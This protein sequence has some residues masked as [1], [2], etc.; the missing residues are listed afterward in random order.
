MNVRSFNS[1]TIVEACRC[2]VVGHNCIAIHAND[3]VKS[4]EIII[5]NAHFIL[6]EKSERLFQTTAA[7]TRLSARYTIVDVRKR[8]A[9]A[10]GE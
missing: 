1:C 4:G 8:A 2:V 5:A 7:G 10:S 6:F 3:P 9:S